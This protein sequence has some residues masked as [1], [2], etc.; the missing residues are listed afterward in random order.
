M[1]EEV[2]WRA[3]E[4]GFEFGYGRG[5]LMEAGRLAGCPLRWRYECD[6]TIR[7]SCLV[8]RHSVVEGVLFW[9]NGGVQNGHPYDYLFA[10]YYART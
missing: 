7:F 9:W 2:S 1:G 3:E 10:T 5:G 8:R 4:E 6:T